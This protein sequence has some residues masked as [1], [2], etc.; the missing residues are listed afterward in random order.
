M[1]GTW[2]DLFEA[3]ASDLFVPDIAEQFACEARRI[4]EKP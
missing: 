3:T 1:F 2:L 4:A